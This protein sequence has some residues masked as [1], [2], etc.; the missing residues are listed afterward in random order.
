MTYKT[1]SQEQK[2]QVKSLFEDGKNKCEISRITGIPRA[3][4][5]KWIHPTYIRKTGKPRNTYKPIVDFESYLNTEEKKR[6]YSFILGV[7]LCDGHISRYKTFRAPCI[8]FFNDLKYPLNTQEWKEKLQIIL[9][10]NKINVYKKSE[11]NCCVVLAYS[12]KLL[13][14]FP[15]YGEGKKHDRK[16]TLAPWQKQILDQYPEEFIRGCIQSDGCIYTQKISDKFSYKR[17]NFINKSEDI[18]NFFL[19]SLERIGILKQKYFSQSRK[20][21]VVQNFSKEQKIILE[22][23]ISKKE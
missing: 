23:I 17:Y 20:L 5:T 10:E 18:I 21:F 16:L 22:T 4:L 14:L 3:T 15:Q 19:S 1:Y 11:S 9:P 7:Y 2:D 6:A 12:R 13:D 8:R